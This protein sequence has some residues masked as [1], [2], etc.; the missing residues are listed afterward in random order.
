MDSEVSNGL[1]LLQKAIRSN[2][3]EVVRDMLQEN[4]KLLN[5]SDS[6]Q[7]QAVDSPLFIAMMQGHEE[8]VKVLIE[9]GANVNDWLWF[10]VLE[11][12]LDES[13][14]LN[15]I[16]NVKVKIEVKKRLTFFH[17]MAMSDKPLINEKILDLLIKHDGADL[18]A[19][20]YEV[21]TPLQIAITKGNVE[22][23]EILL[24]N[25]AKFDDIEF[26]INLLISDKITSKS[27]LLRL[28]IQYG[29]DVSF[30][31]ENNENLLHLFSKS[32]D[33]TSEIEEAAKVLLDSGV[34]L[35]EF[36][37]DG[38]TALYLA[39]Y[40]G[41]YTL[42]K[43]LVENGADVNVKDKNQGF[44]PLLIALQYGHLYL[45]CLFLNAEINAKTHSG[46]TALHDACS[47]NC[48]D[49]F[50]GAL[51]QKGANVCAEDKNG[52][53]P[54]SLIEFK[55]DGGGES[56]SKILIREF[57]KLKFKNLSIPKKDEDCIRENPKLLSYFEGCLVDLSEMEDTIF[58][59][60]YSYYSI[61]MMSKT[62][63]K[64]SKLT[65]NTEF[66]INF[67]SVMY[68]FPF[69]KEDLRSILFDA[70]STR[71]RHEEIYSRL[72]FIFGDFFP[73]LVLRKLLEN[74]EVKDLPLQ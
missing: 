23:A 44:F 34:L 2:S 33:D 50:V 53:T 3:V 28:L 43:F 6:L 40:G 39:V 65:K 1:D 22:F 20:D 10:E 36:N 27:V 41:N 21:A 63:K 49:I 19:T 46:W 70:I 61:L 45:V 15:I 51:I 26:T 66:V 29:L 73:D 47:N 59:G 48:T 13:T 67:E 8:I 52:T 62:I 56:C 60:S 14:S 9:F 55:E 25:G 71:D 68:T 11:E 30:H 24:K 31:N 16:F 58:Y 74:F 72:K 37:N 35:D 42:A 7:V 32:D 4:P 69:F 38:I 17:W 57:A 64:L 54:F 18:N 5:L 12:V